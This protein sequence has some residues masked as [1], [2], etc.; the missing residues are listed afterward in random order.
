MVLMVWWGCLKVL[1]TPFLGHSEKR[2]MLM[3]PHWAYYLRWY[4]WYLRKALVVLFT[5]CSSFFEYVSHLPCRTHFR[6]HFTQPS[7]NLWNFMDM[8]HI[9]PPQWGTFSNLPAASR[10][11]WLALGLTAFFMLKNHETSQ[12][13]MNRH[14][15]MST[16]W[17]RNLGGEKLSFR[18]L[19]CESNMFFSLERGFYYNFQHFSAP[20]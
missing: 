12:S 4:I 1:W 2:N 7:P 20:F 15:I 14:D 17:R 18:D 10:V 3:L 9:V 6:T 5:S 13:A 16:S 8:F 19:V 11:H